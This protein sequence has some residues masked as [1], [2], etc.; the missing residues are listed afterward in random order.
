MPDFDSALKGAASAILK[1]ELTDEERA[2][3]RDLADTL[4]MGSVEDYLYM[5]MIFKRNEDRINGKLDAFENAI[6]GKLDAVA[7]LDKKINETLESS[8]HRILGEGAARIGVEM[9]EKIAADTKGVLSSFGEYHI[10]RG[11]TILA[12]FLCVTFAI[13]YRLG[14]AGILNAVP[15]GSMLEAVLFLPAGWSVFF[16]GATYTFLWAGDHWN[17]IKK[18]A[19][20]KILMGAQIFSLLMLGLALL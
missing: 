9:S 4:G 7:A 17:R 5:L 16:C 11:R 1:R 15:G 12:G 14:E 3:F 6:D 2:E 8:I 19:L 20:Y 13:A 18:T 10:L